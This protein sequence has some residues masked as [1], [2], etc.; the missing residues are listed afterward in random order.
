MRTYQLNRRQI[1]EA[2]RKEGRRVDWIAK[3]IGLGVGHTYQVLSGKRRIR[4]ASLELLAECLNV[5]PQ[6]LIDEPFFSDQVG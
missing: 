3:R 2:I 4:V 1:Q 5:R 6:D